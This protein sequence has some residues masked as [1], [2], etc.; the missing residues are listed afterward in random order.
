MTGLNSSDYIRATAE[1]W[2][3]TDHVDCDHCPMLETYARKQ[4]RRTGEYLID[5]RVTGNY[6]PLK[7]GGERDAVSDTQSE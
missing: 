4:C 1:I 3:V 7:F 2:F 5:T 6:C